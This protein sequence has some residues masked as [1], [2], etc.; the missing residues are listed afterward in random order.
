MPSL[1]ARA[2]RSFTGIPKRAEEK[3]REL[4]IEEMVEEE[5]ISTLRFIRNQNGSFTDP[6]I[7]ADYR[8]WQSLSMAI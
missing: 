6:E 1:I 7:E 4:F 5:N 8:N 3:S 2:I